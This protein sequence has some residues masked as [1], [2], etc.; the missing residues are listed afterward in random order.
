L[1]TTT[2]QT[3][4]RFDYRGETFV[5]SPYSALF[6][7]SPLGQARARLFADYLKASPEG[8][9]RAKNAGSADPATVWG[10]LEPE[11]KTTFLAVTA[12][13]NQLVSAKSGTILSWFERLD[14]IHGSVRPGGGIYADNQA[15]RLYIHLSQPGIAHVKSGGNFENSCTKKTVTY[16]VWGLKHPDFCRPNKKFERQKPTKNSPRIQINV[17]DASG[18]AD[19][20]LDY[21]YDNDQ[22][23]TKDNS[24]VLGSHP[25]LNPK[26]YPP[27][28]ELF[29]SQYCAVGF[30]KEAP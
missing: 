4:E 3:D 10:K 2:G 30:H 13:A 20:D 7:A 28:P 27:H 8:M 12:A 15:F 24:N 21:D 16:G 18:C 22:H 26:D 5:M 29:V 6:D 9:A 14:Q 19:V 25:D 11:E 1:Q 23:F 17:T